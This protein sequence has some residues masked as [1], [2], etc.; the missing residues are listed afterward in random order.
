MAEPTVVHK[1][2][3][4]DISLKC[5]NCGAYQTLTGFEP[6][7]GYNSYTFE[8][9]NDTCDAEVTRTILEVPVVLDIFYQKHPDCGGAG[10]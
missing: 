2:N 10:D 6:G 4:R 3:I 8:C 1:F 9:E 5:G 7:D